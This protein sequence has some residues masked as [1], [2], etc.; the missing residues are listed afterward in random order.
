MRHWS[1]RGPGRMVEWHV[2]RKGGWLR[3]HTIGH[4]SVEQ[5]HAPHLAT[6]KQ[7]CSRH[8]LQFCR[9][10]LGRQAAALRLRAGQL[11]ACRRAACNPGMVSPGLPSAT[12]ECARRLASRRRSPQHRGHPLQRQS[13]AMEQAAAATTR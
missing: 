9:R 2:E 10:Q 13:A 8:R 6:Q 12:R 4:A 7:E 11:I 3:E 1:R 5:A